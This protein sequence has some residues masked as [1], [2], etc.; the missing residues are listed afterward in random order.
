MFDDT[1]NVDPISR[2]GQCLFQSPAYHLPLMFKLLIRLLIIQTIVRAFMIQIN[3]PISA[4]NR[5]VLG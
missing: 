2:T 1:L 5:S 3:G 4:G